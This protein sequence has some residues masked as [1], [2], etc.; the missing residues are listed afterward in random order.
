MNIRTITR[1]AA[2]LTSLA[3][4]TVPLVAAAQFG[5]NVVQRYN[6]PARDL[7][8]T[9]LNIINFVL[10]LVGILALAYL[11]YGGFRY[12]ASRGDETALEEAKGIITNA[13]IGIVV[14]GV[15]AAVVNFV[16]QAVLTGA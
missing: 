9:I 12:I 11:V 16:I 10:V 1:R 13:V 6:P 15:A 3:V 8:A 7:P 14:I 2:S 4:V 5:Q